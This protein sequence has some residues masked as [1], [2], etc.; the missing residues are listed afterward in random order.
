MR[1]LAC[2]ILA[3][4]SLYQQ[5]AV[6]ADEP[7]EITFHDD[8]TYRIV[9]EQELKLDLAVPPGDGPFPAIVFVHGGGW[10]MGNRSRYW[11]ET[12]EA[13]RR[14]FVA[15]TIS[16][17]L[18]RTGVETPSVDGFPAALEDVKAA[19]RFLRSNSKEFR[20]DPKRI[21]I[22]G[23]SAGG[24][25]A[26]LAGLTQPS[27]GFE[28]SPPKNAPSSAVQAV[29]NVSGATDLAPLWQSSERIRPVLVILLGGNPQTESAV[30]G[31]A[32]PVTYARKDAPPIL[33]IHGASDSL[34]PAQQA[35]RLDAAVK[36][37]GGRHTLLILPEAGH[38]LRG[39]QYRYSLFVTFDFLSKMLRKP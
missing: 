29:V 7:S 6:F 36:K 31:T 16:Y 30:Y 35:R 8:V 18:S 23:E 11:Y 33:T 39:D 1:R 22:V 24:H 5:A 4:L 19:I 21:G 2:A 9:G 17:R 3:A 13:A 20:I 12:E 34:V 14:G 27:D 25:L 10:I 38:R 28:G 15:A 37:A 26:L 32:S